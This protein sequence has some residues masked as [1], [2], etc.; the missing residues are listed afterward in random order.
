MPFY[1][2]RIFYRSKIP[3][4]IAARFLTLSGFSLYIVVRDSAILLL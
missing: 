3:Y 2:N 1:E 4:K